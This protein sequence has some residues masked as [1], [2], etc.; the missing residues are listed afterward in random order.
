MDSIT[1]LFILYRCD[2]TTGTFTV[3][4]GGDGFY[5]FSVYLWVLPNKAAYFEIELNGD[6]ICTAAAEVDGYEVTSCT[7][8]IYAVEGIVLKRIEIW[9]VLQLFNKKRYNK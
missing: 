7:A 9:R 2:S 6:L 4:S 5:Y 8:A 1:S 3:P